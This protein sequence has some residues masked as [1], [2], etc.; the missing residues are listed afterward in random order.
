MCK[1]NTALIE[2]PT[3]VLPADIADYDYSSIIE[4]AERADKLVAALNKMMG[5]AIKITTHLD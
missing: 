5:A 4:Q 1:E 2:T 3:T